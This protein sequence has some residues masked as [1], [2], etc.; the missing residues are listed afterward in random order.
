VDRGSVEVFVEGGLTS[1]T[2]LALPE[3]GATGLTLLSRHGTSGFEDVQVR[4]L[5]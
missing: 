1:V 5:G 2:T 3:V 4:P